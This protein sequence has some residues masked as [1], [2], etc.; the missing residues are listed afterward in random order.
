MAVLA[1]SPYCHNKLAV[2]NKACKCNSGMDKTKK[3][4][5]F[6]YWIRYR[7]PGGKQ[8]RDPVGFKISEAK[9]ADSK[10]KVQKGENR[11]FDIKPESRMT[12][13]ELADWY[14]NLEKVKALK[15]F[16]TVK[17]VQGRIHGLNEAK[18]RYK[19]PHDSS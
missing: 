10:R 14:L 1:E 2:K 6:R 18:G 19:S 9:D 16:A 8:K 7:L 3:A 11:I 15:S 13:T 5:K 4:K 17:N 12:F